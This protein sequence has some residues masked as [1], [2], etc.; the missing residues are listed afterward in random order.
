MCNK[1][2]SAFVG[3]CLKQFYFST[4]KLALNYFK[5]ISEDYCSRWIFS[6][7]FIVAEI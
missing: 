1:I 3:V 6:N 7:M 5:I 2:I 4:W